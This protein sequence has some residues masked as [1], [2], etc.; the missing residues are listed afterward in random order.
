MMSL[1]IYLS[2]GQ[3]QYCEMSLFFFPKPSRMSLVTIIYLEIREQI[4]FLPFLQSK[5]NDIL[6]QARIMLLGIQLVPSLT[7]FPKPT[8]TSKLSILCEQTAKTY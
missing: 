5:L 8:V 2:D 1:V 4:R 6:L 3:N 7:S